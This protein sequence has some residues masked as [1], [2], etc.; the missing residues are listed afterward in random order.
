MV[1]ENYRDDENYRKLIELFTDIG[2]EGVFSVEFLVDK[3]DTLYFSEINFRNST[4]SYASTTLGMNLLTLWAEGM[5][6]HTV[7]EDTVKTIPEN[8]IA[9]DEY[10]DFK[11]CVLGRRMS[12]SKW[13]KVYRNSG[14]HYCGNRQDPQPFRSFLFSITRNKIKKILGVKR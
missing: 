12:L 13:L 4:W 3:D 8:F 1:V 5:L 2:F 7:R 10:D 9:M 11:A 14:C 6:T